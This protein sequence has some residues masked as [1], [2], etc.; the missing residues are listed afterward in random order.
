MKCSLDD[1]SVF[2]NVE[3]QPEFPGGIQALM[4]FLSDNLKYPPAAMKNGIEGRVLVRFVVTQEGKIE[5]AEIVRKVNPDLEKEALRV[6][7][8]MPKWK[9]GKVE[10]KPV[11][12][13]YT[14]PVMFRLN[15]DENKGSGGAAK[16][17]PG[18]GGPGGQFGGRGG[19]KPAP[20]FGSYSLEKNFEGNNVLLLGMKDAR[21]N[22]L[23][24]TITNKMKTNNEALERIVSE[25]VFGISGSFGDA[26]KEFLGK[27]HKENFV[28]CKLS[29][30][31]NIEECYN[32]NGV[33]CVIY[34]E[35]NANNLTKIS[36]YMFFVYDTN[37]SRIISL[38]DLVSNALAAHLKGQGIDPESTTNIKI[39]ENGFVV[40]TPA[41]IIT[42]DAEKLKANLSDYALG[43][44]GM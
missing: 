43:L 28:D 24:L 6:V 15:R 19:F 12:V 3:E 14:L 18:M 16:P 20:K 8:H 32:K 35:L 31:F 11:R 2:V 42:I 27:F 33:V 38:Q 21:N 36:D 30:S 22:T 10:G 44:L 23:K 13:L 41:S 40:T 39:E 9:P 26:A 34:R 29:Q 7:N 17:R 37:A 1:D 4:K 25:K 5:N